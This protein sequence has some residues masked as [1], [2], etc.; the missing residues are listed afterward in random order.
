MDPWIW[1]SL[2]SPIFCL[3]YIFR[4]RRSKRTGMSSEYL[5]F[6]KQFFLV[7]LT[8]STFLSA[9]RN[10]ILALWLETNTNDLF[11]PSR[12]FLFG[13]SLRTLNLQETLQIG[14]F[15]TRLNS[16]TPN[17]YH[18]YVEA[19]CCSVPHREVTFANTAWEKFSVQTVLTCKNNSF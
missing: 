17:S 3:S 12:G 8:G 16:S 11:F 2:D 18:A 6:I 13:R 15:P 19:C 5:T 9:N 10:N 1:Q 14:H 7:Q 4:Y